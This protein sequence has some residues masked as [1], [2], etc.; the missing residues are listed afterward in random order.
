MLLRE[1]SKDIF[2]LQHC[3]HHLVRTERRLNITYNIKFIQTQCH[4]RHYISGG[5]SQVVDGSDVRAFDHKHRRAATLAIRSKL[6]Y[7]WKAPLIDSPITISSQGILTENPFTL[8]AL[9]LH[10][11]YLK[12]SINIARHHNLLH[13]TLFQFP[14]F[15]P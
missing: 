2:L 8:N 4:L 10:R 12:A 14:W 9:G 6:T 5:Q 3:L 13:A 15:S 11:P 7:Y 1:E